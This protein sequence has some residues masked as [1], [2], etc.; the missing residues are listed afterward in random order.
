MTT[1]ADRIKGIRGNASVKAFAGYLGVSA[2]YI[3][4]IES[5]EKTV[6]SETLAELI[7]TKYNLERHWILTGEGP[8]EKKESPFMMG[9]ASGPSGLTDTAIPEEAQTLV[10]ELLFIYNNGAEEDRDRLY[11]TI[12][13]LYN[14]V[15]DGVSGSKGSGE[16]TESRFPETEK[17]TD[18]R[19]SA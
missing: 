8:I 5:G 1:L 10:R 16:D 14:K 4:A 17:D 13:R 9:V 7:S 11:G 15:M 18:E 19:K 6:I 12:G 2:A 3:Y